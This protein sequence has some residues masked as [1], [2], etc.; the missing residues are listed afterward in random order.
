MEQDKHKEIDVLQKQM[1]Q[2]M[3]WNEKLLSCFYEIK[4]S[5]ETSKV[6]PGNV[7][8]ATNLDS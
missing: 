2:Q 3:D 1:H 8:T 6:G 7:N 4:H 5:L